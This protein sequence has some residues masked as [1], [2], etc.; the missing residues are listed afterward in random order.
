[1]VSK[2]EGMTGAPGARRKGEAGSAL[3]VAIL[4][5]VIMSLM[6]LAFA[7]V[8]DTENRISVNE[9][10]QAEALYAAE[11]TVRLVKGWFDNPSPSTGY[12]VPTVSQVNRSLRYVDNDGDG[13]YQ[14]YSTAPAPWNVIY[15]SGTDDLFEKPYRG[16]PT[17]MLVGTQSNPDVRISASGSAAQQSFLNTINDTLFPNYPSPT[18][19]AKV[20]QIDV[21]SAPILGTASQRIRYGMATVLVT[22]GIYEKVGTPS[23]TQVAERVVKAIL[24]ELLYPGPAGPIQ[25]C[26]DMDFHGNFSVHWGLVTSAGNMT[27]PSSIDNKVDSGVPWYTL[28]RNITRDLNLDGTVAAGSPGSPTPDDQ[29]ANSQIDFDEWLSSGNLE[30]PWLRYWS[31]ADITKNGSVISPGCSSPNCQPAPWFQPP[32]TLTNTDDHSNLFKNVAT[33]TC[34]NIDYD[35]WKGL[36]LAG[37]KNIHYYA[38]DAGSGLFK[39]NG[40][41]SAIDFVT[42]TN[43]KNGLF[44][45]D[46]ADGIRPHDDN[47]DGHYDNL[48]PDIQISGGAWQAAGF[49][50]FNTN[51]FRTTGSGS[52]STQTT[53]YAPAEPCIDQNSNGACDTGEYFLDL[54][55]AA[56]PSGVNWTK[57]A[58]RQQNVGGYVRQDPSLDAASDGKYLT[59]VNMYGVVYNNGAYNAQ[60]NW[61]YFGSVVTHE[62][63]TAAGLSG[64]T[65]VYFDERIIKGA[66]P[67]PDLNLPRTAVSLWETDM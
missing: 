52:I 27:L 66:W 41:G 8:A 59:D 63:T 36:A 24:N 3:V 62:G 7:L 34:P 42:A 28:T 37:G 50:F 20:R 55:Y 44:F 49:I 5:M 17:Q 29:N 14:L 4:I 45:F 30:D 38:Y 33:S 54:T 31:E 10:H 15:R 25:S 40:T 21:Y 35:F 11:G 26:A 18:V 23:E 48:T 43:G 60:G 65:N 46:T 67:P 9:R 32:S 22:V 51:T 61:I 58:L 6:G 47:S 57:N 53:M 2:T 39:E 19:R 12:L 56:S 16:T 64:T 1:M 13:T